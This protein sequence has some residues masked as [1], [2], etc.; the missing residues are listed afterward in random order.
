MSC[1]KFIDSFNSHSVS[2]YRF[3]NQSNQ[4]NIEFNYLISFFCPYPIELSF[5]FLSYILLLSFKMNLTIARSFFTE[6]KIKIETIP[7]E[8][9][10]KYQFRCSLPCS[11]NS[12]ISSSSPGKC[13]SIMSENVFQSYRSNNE[14]RA[15]AS[16]R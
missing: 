14:I 8:I 9:F 12:L 10:G 16:S 5:S 3:P 13:G 1:I 4:Q 11:S 15:R 6:K 2:V 7:K